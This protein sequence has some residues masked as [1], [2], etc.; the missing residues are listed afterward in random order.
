V[1]RKIR[2]LYQNCDLNDFVV[3]FYKNPNQLKK[4]SERKKSPNP[5][6]T[7]RIFRVFGDIQK[8]LFLFLPSERFAHYFFRAENICGIFKR[9]FKINLF[10]FMGI[11]EVTVYNSIIKPILVKKILSVNFVKVLKIEKL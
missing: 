10:S 7:I 2:E 4:A 8:L 3:L 11:C 1:V 9:V 6:Q 5:H